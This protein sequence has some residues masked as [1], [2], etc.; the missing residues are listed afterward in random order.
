MVNFKPYGGVFGFAPRIHAILLILGSAILLCGSCTKSTPESETLDVEHWSGPGDEP[1][2]LTRP[3]GLIASEDRLYVVDR[4]GRLNVFDLEGNFVH[5]W[6]L[7]K[8]KRGTPT[9]LLLAHDGNLIVPDTHNSRVLE[10]SPM[11]ELLWSYGSYGDGPGQFSFVT[12]VEQTEEGCWLIA[13]YGF[14]DRIQIISPE[15]DYIDSFGEYGDGPGQFSRIMGMTMAPGGMLYVADSVNN[16]IQALK[17][18]GHKISYVLQ[19]GGF[20][21]DHGQLTYPYDIRYSADTRLDQR[22][23]LYVCEYGSHRIQ[24]FTLDGK[25]LGTWGKVGN[26]DGELWN[27]W[28]VCV[29]PDYRVAVADADNHRITVIGDKGWILPSQAP[30]QTEGTGVQAAGA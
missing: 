12:A 27:P 16:R 7:Q 17:V 24:R 18:D 14:T 21:K 6:I 1:G 15:L 22:G 29:L 3:R 4:S 8:Q 2:F 30:P 20:G 11:G 5:Y 10:F 26:K 23:I 9:S 25:P 13:E 28:G 19:F